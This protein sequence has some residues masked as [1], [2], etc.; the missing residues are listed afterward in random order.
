M[1]R[2]IGM[3]ACGIALL[4][5]SAWADEAKRK[6]VDQLSEL[7]GTWQ[8]FLNIPGWLGGG[9]VEHADNRWYGFHNINFD[10][11]GSPYISGTSPF[12]TISI[13][14]LTPMSS[15]Q[16]K[17]LQRYEFFMQDQGENGDR[18]YCWVYVFDRSPQ[19]NLRNDFIRGLV[20][21]SP[22]VRRKYSANSYT[23]DCSSETMR[24]TFTGIRR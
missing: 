16:P 15:E 11:E 12:D 6:Q 2:S 21:V 18:V 8:F 20:G 3:I 4:C 13:A 5:S 19:E 1:L 9:Q 17:S 14:K 10:E 22:G 23:Y 7:L 24:G